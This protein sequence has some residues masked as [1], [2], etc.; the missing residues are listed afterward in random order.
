MKVMSEVI[1]TAY[2]KIG[3]EIFMKRINSTI[4]NSSNVLPWLS[5]HDLAMTL[6]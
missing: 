2:S 4:E 3:D 1:T 6:S 5:C